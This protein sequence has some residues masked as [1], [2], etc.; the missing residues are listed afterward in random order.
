MTNEASIAALLELIRE[1]QT[2]VITSHMRPD[3]DAIGSA[4]GLFHLLEAI[5]KQ[6]TV[7]FTDAIPEVYR[8]LPGV[9]RIT[10][11]IP[12]GPLD[13][14]IFLESGTRERASIDQA[15]LAAAAP[16]FTIHIDHHRSGTA[17]ADFNWIDPAACAVGA[18][19]YD[20]AVASGVLISKAVA[21]CLYT[22]VLT[23]T[24]SFNFP[25]TTASTFAL[26]AHLVECGVVPNE[27]A[28][29]VFFSNPPARSRVLGLVLSRMDIQG[30]VAW[31]YLTLD[32]LKQAGAAVEDSEGAVN[33]LISVA[34]VQAAALVRETE[35]GTEFRVSLRSKGGVD[36]SC[37]AE[38][39]GG[40]GH[41]NASGCT[42]K[43]TLA[44]ASAS[45][46]AA[47]REAANV[48][49]L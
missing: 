40:G 27:I 11:H 25:G 26:A 35:P 28:Q 2:F 10:T 42:L 9:D 37:V 3:G 8:F 32:D 12:S 1:R 13:A 20:L 22:A 7:V 21:D 24:G 6:A 49:K 43:G 46:L 41:R 4:L 18:M 38:S 39:F 17:F 16:A 36:V 15:E 30:N 47:L 29:A 44:E 31:S 5:G 33:Q 23:D 45:V 34:G 14:L 19:I 48:S